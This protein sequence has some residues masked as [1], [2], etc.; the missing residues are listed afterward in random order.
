M[1]PEPIPDLGRRLG[2]DDPVSA[3][4]E[5]LGGSGV[6]AVEHPD[7]TVSLLGALGPGARV[8]LEES[9]LRGR[10]EIGGIEWLVASGP[11]TEVFGAYVGALA[12]R[13]GRRGRS[14]MRVWCSWYSYY[15]SIT[16]AALTEVLDGLGDLPF[17]VVQVDDGWQRG[18]GD[19]EP[20]PGF[21][22]GMAA[23]ADRIRSTGRI[24]GLWLAPLIAHSSSGLAARRPELLLRDDRGD[25]VVAGINWGGPYFAIDPTADASAGYLADLIGRT[26]EWGYDYLKLDFLYAGAFPGVHARATPREVAYREAAEVMRS[27]AG[28]DCYLLACGAPII[29][30]VGVFD[31]IRI[32]PDVAEFWE[33]PAMVALGDESA[34]G[35][36]NALA[37][38]SQRLWLRGAID[39]DPDVAFFRSGDVDLD[40]RTRAALRDL[41]QVAGFLG[42]SDPPGDLD[43]S[44]QQELVAWLTEAPLVEQR[45]RFGWSVDHRLVDFSWVFDRDR[46]LES[47]R[48]P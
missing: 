16:E 24:P 44:E 32:G 34:R 37:T 18:I 10:S 26:R 29:A 27:A 13:L 19:W 9:T 5:Q 20:N 39:T 30:S 11:E 1:R 14:R 8:T 33:D 28:D 47:E 41:A 40:G 4:S 42:V 38:A 15:E 25:P 23:T 17:D 2:H 48:S 31:G 35:A 3:F 21:P 45:D 12:E 46:A 7:G 43:D 22:G 36:R 6:G